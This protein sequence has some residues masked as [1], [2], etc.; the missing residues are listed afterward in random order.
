MLIWSTLGTSEQ[1]GSE[2]DTPAPPISSIQ[3]GGDRESKGLE[4]GGVW[5][6]EGEE[7][8]EED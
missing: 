3:Q 8:E 2:Q 5:Q 1:N 7:K 6:K 4:E